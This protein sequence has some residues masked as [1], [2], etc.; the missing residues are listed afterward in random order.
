MTQERTANAHSPRWW[1]RVMRLH[2]F[3]CLSHLYIA[4]MLTGHW[5]LGHM[6][7]RVLVAYVIW[8]ALGLGAITWA[9]VSGWCHRL[10]DPNMFAQHQVL[11]IGGTFGLLAWAPATGFQCFLMLLVCCTD[12][13]IAPSRRIF[14][15]TWVITALGAISAIFIQ[16]P[17]LTPPLET[18]EEQGLAAA[19][20]IG[21][22][23]RSVGLLTYFNELRQKLYDSR[24]RLATAM[25]QLENLASRDELT[26]LDNRR[27][28]TE[29][30]ALQVNQQKRRGGCVG[31]ALLD[32]DHFK[33][34]ND[35]FGHPI[36]DQVL[37]EF[38]VVVRSALRDT[39]RVGRYGGEEFLLVLSDVSVGEMLEPLERIRQQIEAHPWQKI[40]PELR[41]T[42]SIGGSIVRPGNTTEAA[43]RDADK[44]L[45]SA[46]HRG[47]NRVEVPAESG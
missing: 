42:V 41:I 38:A 1:Q 23:F 26:G 7:G 17:A 43:I 12:G 34:V 9:Y 15:L 18:I 35:R 16:G 40:D 11:A 6:D 14:V 36:G 13:F 32:I 37:R 45:Y 28:I 21:A 27:T 31:V 30:L 33:S 25:T 39:D 3:V 8:L 19:A 24:A 10:R 2:V 29:W 4:A 20:M 44:S 46:K 47:R 5:S 22:L